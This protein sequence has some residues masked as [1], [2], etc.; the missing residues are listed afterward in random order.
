MG[1]LAV[2]VGPVLGQEGE[3]LPH[4]AKE[5]FAAGGGE[6]RGGGLLLVEE[7][8]EQL[9]PNILPDSDPVRAAARGHQSLQLV[10][11]HKVRGTL[12]D[13]LWDPLQEPQ[14][15]VPAITGGAGVYGLSLMLAAHP[16]VQEGQ[17]LEEELP[18]CLHSLRGA[19]R[20]EWHYVIVGGVPPFPLTYPGV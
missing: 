16:P 7:A 18:G 14:G 5:H 10:S 19:A 15:D 4:W 3:P 20:V 2:G 6:G 17:P 13:P 12:V 1:V 9:V 8:G 11:A